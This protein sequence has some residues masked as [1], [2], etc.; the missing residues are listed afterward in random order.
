MDAQGSSHTSASLLGRLGSNPE[1]GAAWSEFVLRY[2]P[3]ILQWC[4]GW[5]LQQADAED[6]TQDVLLRVAR[7]MQTF[8]YDPSR[9]FRAWLRTVAY[10]AWCDW[11]EA[12]SRRV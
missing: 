4:R 5:R 8:R 6:V 3:K 1:D 9:S 7:Q 10:R 12:R 11:L 2:G